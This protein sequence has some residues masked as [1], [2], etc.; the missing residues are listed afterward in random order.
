MKLKY[1]ILYVENVEQTLEFYESAFGLKRAMLHEG[2]D[3]A[4]LDTGNTTL[5]FSSLDLM[6]RLGKGAQRPTKG[7]PNFEIAFETDDVAGSLQKALDAGAELVQPVEEMPWGQTT[8]YVHDINGF[9]IEICSP[10][11]G[12]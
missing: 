10:V 9:L 4:E 5:S 3:Y 8:S 12:A 6:N 1:T 7:K 11:S 2:G